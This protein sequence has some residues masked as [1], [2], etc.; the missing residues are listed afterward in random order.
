M[1]EG[2][3]E[4][5]KTGKKAQRRE[6]GKAKKKGINADFIKLSYIKNFQVLSFI[7]KK[8][9]STLRELKVNPKKAKIL[10]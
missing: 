4:V 2:K 5:K 7:E 1:G 10:I 8:I 6:G 9:S 3:K